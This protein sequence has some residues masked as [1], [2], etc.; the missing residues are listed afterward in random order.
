MKLKET[1]LYEPVTKL[2]PS[3]NIYPE[4][5]V[6]SHRPDIVVEEE[7]GEHKTITIV[8]LKTSLSLALIEQAYHWINKGDYIYVA[9]PRPKKVNSF[10]VRLL[11]SKGIG[12][13]VV[14]KWGAQIYKKAIKQDRCSIKWD[15]MLHEFYKLNECGGTD[16]E[17]M[18]SYKFT[19]QCVR[20]YLSTQKK[21]Q[22]I[23][24]IVKGVDKLYDGV[25]SSH[26]RNPES[27]LRKALTEYETEW[28]KRSKVG[29]RIH[30]STK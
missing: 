28:C 10:A 13:I 17:Y 9:I 30:F 24:D 1:D 5:V 25:V 20:E 27:S 29:G 4:V 7:L 26:Y 22:T 14:D 6:Y 11:S 21:S 3:G 12:V 15:N 19:I 8:E 18:T 2:F 16:G 23:K